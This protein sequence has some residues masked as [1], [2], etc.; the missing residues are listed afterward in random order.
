MATGS[1]YMYNSAELSSDDAAWFQSVVGS[2]N[3]FAGATRYDIQY[4]V[5][6]VS[7]HMGAP[8]VGAKMAVNRILSYLAATSDFSLQQSYTPLTDIAQYYSDSDCGGDVPYN[9][10]SQSGTLLMLN[11]VPVY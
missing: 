3:Y 6:K 2:L 8:T 1:T 9:S 4:A 10:K 7:Q 5:S 11:G